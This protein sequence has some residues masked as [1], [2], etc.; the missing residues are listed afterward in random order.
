LKS[1]DRMAR[2]GQSHQRAA[3]ILRRN[4]RAKPAGTI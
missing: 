2:Y 1:F 4:G 3:L